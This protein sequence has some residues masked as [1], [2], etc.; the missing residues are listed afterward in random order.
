MLAADFNADASGLHSVSNF[1]SDHP[2][3]CNFLMADGSV[4]FLREDIDMMS[5][6]ARSTIAGEDIASE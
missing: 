4:T 2:G 3:G 5:Y 1:R 6:Q